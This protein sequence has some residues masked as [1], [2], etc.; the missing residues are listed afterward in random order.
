MP[1]FTYGKLLPFVKLE[2]A[3]IVNKYFITIT[4][5]NLLLCEYIYIYINFL[6]FVNQISKI[7]LKKQVLYM[8][9]SSTPSPTGK[10]TVN[11]ILYIYRAQGIP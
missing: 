3:T 10:T 11:N 6:P 7:S 2:N 1:F 4:L 5:N 8:F 9:Q